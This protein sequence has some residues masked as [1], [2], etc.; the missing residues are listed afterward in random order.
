MP[1]S[2]KNVADILKLIDA[3]S[4]ETLEVELDGMRLVVRKGASHGETAPLETPSA[5]VEAAPI[6]I[7]DDDDDMDGE[8]V[9]VGATSVRADGAVEVRAPMMGTFYRAPSPSDP[10]YVEIGQTVQAG[11][12]LCIIEVM[13]LFTTLKAEQGGTVSEI[14]A[15]NGVLVNQG[16]V[17]FVIKPA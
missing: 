14:P 17:L 16:D 1:L 9:T 15:E 5:E 12:A 13:K 8:H 10:A 2:Y 11:G 4:L 6:D 3:S 7:P